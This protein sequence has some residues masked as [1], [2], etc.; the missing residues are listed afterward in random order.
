MSCYNN[1]KD[2]DA[3]ILAFLNGFYD[4][5]RGMYHQLQSMSLFLLDTC[6][7]ILTIRNDGCGLGCGPQI[8]AFIAREET[9]EV[10]PVE[11]RASALLTREAMIVSFLC[12]LQLQWCQ[13]M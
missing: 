2:V 10:A 4:A 6:Q 13:E 7:L 3:I 1:G 5:F 8:L 9:E 11:P 12:D